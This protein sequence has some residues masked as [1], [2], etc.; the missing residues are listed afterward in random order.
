MY[1][2]NQSNDI[3]SHWVM[4]VNS[5]PKPQGEKRKLFIQH[6]DSTRRDVELAFEVLHSQFA[7]KHNLAGT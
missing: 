6:Q 4:F 5:V 7:V 2:L 3:H 1:I